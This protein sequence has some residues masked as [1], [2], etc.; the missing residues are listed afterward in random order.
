MAVKPLFI[1]LLGLP[2]APVAGQTDPAAAPTVLFDFD[3]GKVGDWFR[4]TSKGVM[5]L[6]PAPEFQG[7]AVAPP[8]GQALRV[9]SFPRTFLHSLDG[10]MPGDWSSFES[11]SMWVYRTEAAAAR[12]PTTSFEVQLLQEQGVRFWRRVQIEHAGWQ[13]LELPLKWFSPLV[14]GY[15]AGASSPFL[16]CTSAI[17]V[18]C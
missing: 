6:R 18:S 7:D 1:L 15:R 2:M 10:K 9:Q 14:A 5:G 4:L 16:G 3:S 17:A 8:G 11:L 12:H 13:R